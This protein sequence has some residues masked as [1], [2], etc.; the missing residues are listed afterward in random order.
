MRLLTPLAP[1]FLVSCAVSDRP[2]WSQF[3]STAGKGSSPHSV[4]SALGELF[5]QLSWVYLTIRCVRW[6]RL[7][8]TRA[9]SCRQFTGVFSAV[10][11]LLQLPPVGVT[12]G[13]G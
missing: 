13:S 11:Q 12:L 2:G 1:M 9:F 7:Q 4:S 8:S 10:T 5:F 6:L 3:E